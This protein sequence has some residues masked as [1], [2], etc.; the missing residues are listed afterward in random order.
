MHLKMAACFDSGEKFKV[1]TSFCSPKCTALL[2][3][4]LPS[5]S[6]EM[7]FPF[8]CELGDPLQPEGGKKMELKNVEIQPQ[9]WASN[10]CFPVRKKTSRVIAEMP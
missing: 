8:M 10:V 6:E 1:C 5:Y 3:P 7:S 9:N 4:L 2:S